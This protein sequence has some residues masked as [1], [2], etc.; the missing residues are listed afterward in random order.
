L[1]QQLLDNGFTHVHEVSSLLNSAIDPEQ[2][3]QEIKRYESRAELVK[4][5]LRE[6]NENPAV[7]EFDERMFKEVTARLQSERQ[8]LEQ[9]NAQ[10]A[11]L[12]QEITE[13]RSKLVEKNT[14]V[15]DLEKIEKRELNLKELE[16][17]F[18][19]HG[20]VKYVSSI[21]LK[22]LCQTANHRFMKLTKN[23]L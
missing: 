11:V 12:Q 8:R 5:R 15:Q 22:E 9:Y 23:S 3:E 17:L 1:S 10:L 2:W 14:R 19:G 7:R 20:F 6:L 21:Y 13:I 4:E 16:R 18:K